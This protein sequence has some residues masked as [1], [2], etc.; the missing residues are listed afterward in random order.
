MVILITF[1]KIGNIAELVNSSQNNLPRHKPMI[2]IT[3]R[4]I[5]VACVLLSW[6]ISTGPESPESVTT[7]RRPDLYGGTA[8]NKALDLFRA[9][10]C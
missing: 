10:L 7:R 8:E 4:P 1:H 5:K 3:S 2:R 6:L 9:K